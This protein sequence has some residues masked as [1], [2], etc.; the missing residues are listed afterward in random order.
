MGLFGGGNSSTTLQTTNNTQADNQAQA[1]SGGSVAGKDQAVTLGGSGNKN[2]LGGEYNVGSN[3][4]LTINGAAGAEAIA[5][6]FTETLAQIN[7]T[8]SLDRANSNQLV[9]DALN[10]V[11][12]AATTQ[13]TG[14]ISALGQLSLWGLGI[15]AAVLVV[16]F[17]S[18]SK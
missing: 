16:F 8:A 14:G 13:A 10:K 18:K 6:K 5:G 9:T 3:A 7:D 2:V 12:A 4:N 11:A 15:V 1:L 17:W